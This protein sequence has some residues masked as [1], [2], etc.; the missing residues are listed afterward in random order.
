MN[1]DSLLSSIKLYRYAPTMSIC[2]TKNAKS[3]YMAEK[4]LKD[5]HRMVGANVS[6]KSMPGI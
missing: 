1:I 5:F 2:F 4:I 3:T 6:L